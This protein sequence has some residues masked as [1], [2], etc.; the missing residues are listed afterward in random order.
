[1]PEAS[2]ERGF[3]GHGR[4][5]FSLLLVFLYFTGVVYS[6]TIGSLTNS[7]PRNATTTQLSATSILT[8]SLT[9]SSGSNLISVSSGSGSEV[10][11]THLEVSSIHLEISTTST[12]GTLTTA[13][14][15]RPRRPSKTSK[16]PNKQQSISPNLNHTNLEL[17]IF[18]LKG[19]YGA[20]KAYR[21]NSTFPKHRGFP[22]HDSFLL[23]TSAAQA[24]LNLGG[25]FA[26]LDIA[27]L[28]NATATNSTLEKRDDIE[29]DDIT[30][31]A[32][33]T[34]PYHQGVELQP[35]YVLSPRSL[36]SRGKGEHGNILVLGSQSQLHEIENAMAKS[37][38][39]RGELVPRADPWYCDCR[40]PPPAYMCYISIPAL[41]IA[42]VN[43]CYCCPS[44]EQCYFPDGYVPSRHVNP[45][46]CKNNNP[47]LPPV[48]T[49]TKPPTSTP[50]TKKLMRGKSALRV[51]GVSGR[52]LV[53]VINALD[54][55]NNVVLVKRRFARGVLIVGNGENTVSL[56]TK[57]FAPGA[58]THVS[59]INFAAD[60][61]VEVNGKSAVQERMLSAGT[62]KSAAVTSVAHPGIP[63]AIT[64]ASKLGA[65]V[66]A[67]D[68]E[69]V[70]RGKNA[71]TE[72]AY[73]MTGHAATME[74]AA[75]LELAA[76][77]EVVALMRR[78]ASKDNA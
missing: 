7:A 39:K 53:A 72:I 46:A 57:D 77:V 48:A 58:R 20:K 65:K 34:V 54:L 30:V 22:G 78:I 63:V 14:S 76:A 74:S 59:K 67:V 19:G 15:S 70:K 61:V 44:N 47:P 13:T 27:T 2:M 31:F 71:A 28:P 36:K 4:G 3:V 10:S 5:L 25:S 60:G 17:Q 8:E 16:V 51:S 29:V 69:P 11:T 42:A 52:R 33:I 66:H 55:E 68:R 32:P 64:N 73:G 24:R 6:A 35:S 40:Y 56:T 43:I 18:K 62:M 23:P 12:S 75:S 45:M 21:R 26:D 49:T 50:T 37:L 38:V 41:Y 1:M 9:S